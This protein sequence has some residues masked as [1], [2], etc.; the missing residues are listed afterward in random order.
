MLLHPISSEKT[1]KNKRFGR[2]CRADEARYASILEN[3]TRHLRKS[4]VKSRL[5]F[6]SQKRITLLSRAVGQRE[7]IAPGIDV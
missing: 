2:N 6:A 5:I 3:E 1:S 7:V 4:A